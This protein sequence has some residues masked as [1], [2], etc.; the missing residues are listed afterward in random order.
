MM[1]R[2]SPDIMTFVDRIADARDIDDV[3]E[4]ENEF[5][6][7]L[8]HS[9]KI[10]Q[11][12]ASV[13][14]CMDVIVHPF[15][16][17]TSEETKVALRSIDKDRVQ[18]L[19]VRNSPL[20]LL[21]RQEIMGFAA[22][23]LPVISEGRDLA[24][25]GALLTYSPNFFEMWKRSAVYVDKILKGAKPGDLPVEQPT[26]FELIVNLKAAKALGITIPESILLRADEVIR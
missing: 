21:H 3:F 23:R 14:P 7:A 18:A 2:A 19:F 25:A 4:L 20:L 13:L 11:I 26:K 1:E 12:D 24:E 9:G 8:H 5:I 22:K 6:Y 15:G 10:H 17:R 16:V